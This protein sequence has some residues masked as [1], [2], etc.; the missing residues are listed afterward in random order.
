MTTQRGERPLKLESRNQ[1]LV[2]DYCKKDR[3]GEYR[4]S[5]ADL[6]AKY[7][8]S[9]ARIYGILETYKVERRKYGQ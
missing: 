6:I 5:L 7:R 1:E 9:N 4:Y 8:I 3:T 2:A